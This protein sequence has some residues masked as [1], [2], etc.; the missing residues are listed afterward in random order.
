MDIRIPVSMEPQFPSALEI[1]KWDMSNRFTD[2]SYGIETM[3]HPTI[4]LILNH[5]DEDIHGPR[6]PIPVIIDKGQD[7]LI[8]SDLRNHIKRDFQSDDDIKN[9]IPSKGLGKHH[10][11]MIVIL[12]ANANGAI[13]ALW[14]DVIPALTM[15]IAGMAGGKLSLDMEDKGIIED[16]VRLGLV[17][18]IYWNLSEFDI[19]TTYTALK[20][21]RDVE[22][23]KLIEFIKDFKEK[24]PDVKRVSIMDVVVA[25]VRLFETSDRAKG[26]ATLYLE[27]VSSAVFPTMKR[28]WIIGMTY[29]AY[30]ISC[31]YT[32]MTNQFYKRTYIAG[33]I[34]QFK[35]ALDVKEIETKL[36]N[37]F[38]DYNIR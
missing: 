35:R 1:E 33:A 13:D 3:S 5:Y 38:I 28:E 14:K 31:L 23:E 34:Q 7:S 24:N 36:D 10:L 15:V 16:G 6:I 30:L 18:F 32:S 17:T 25:Y 11:E 8:V 20:S 9:G 29:P 2:K 4:R 26:D 22:G 19:A 21:G 27:S 12:H 37:M